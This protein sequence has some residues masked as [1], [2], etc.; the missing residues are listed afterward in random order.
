MLIHSFVSV[1]RLVATTPII[2]PKISVY[3]TIFWG[4]F[5]YYDMV[6]FPL[7]HK[8]SVHLRQV[9][10]FSIVICG[11]SI[12]FVMIKYVASMLSCLVLMVK[13]YLLFEIFTKS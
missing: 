10:N 4:M 8:F 7:K 3:E 2:H 11:L 6:I 5:V 1:M 9:R 13:R 12:S